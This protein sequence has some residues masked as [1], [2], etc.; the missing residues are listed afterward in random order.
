M[1]T[2]ATK[3]D[4]EP[5]IGIPNDV[6]AYIR[7]PR[8]GTNEKYAQAVVANEG[9]SQGAQFIIDLVSVDGIIISTQGYSIGKGWTVSEDGLHISHPMHKNVMKGT[10]YHTL[11][12]RVIK[13][14]EVDLSKY[15]KPTESLSWDGLGFHWMVELLDQVGGQ[16]KSNVPLPTI[17]LGKNEKFTTTASAP[18]Q[19]LP[20]DNKD[21]LAKLA[22]LAKALTRTDFQLQAMRMPEVS[23][24]QNLLANITDDSASGFYAKNH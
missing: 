3:S 18:K 11:Q 21:L 15:G 8:F 2:P 6:D 9:E 13:T 17:F 12:E 23:R 19:A 4:W 10:R 16:K 1:T 24:D 20:T 7:N 22:G 5:A 14:L